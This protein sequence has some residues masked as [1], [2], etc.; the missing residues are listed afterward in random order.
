MSVAARLTGE[1]EGSSPLPLLRSSPVTATPMLYPDEHKFFMKGTDS[2]GVPIKAN[3]LKLLVTLWKS[4]IFSHD[5][6]WRTY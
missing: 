3:L 5:R 6:E 2:S 4:K 1:G